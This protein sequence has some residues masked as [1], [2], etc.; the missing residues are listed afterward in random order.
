MIAEDIM[1]REPL[2]VTE[3]VSIGEA[4]RVLSEAGI[5]HLPVVRGGDVVGILS[6]R[7]FT[8]LGLALVNDVERYDQLR[9]RLSR[10]VS[11]L[12]SGSVVSVSREAPVSEIVELM[13]E[14]KLGAVPVVEGNT[15]E[16]AG[17]VSY[18]DVLRAA[19]DLLDGE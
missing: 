7:D 8:G 6:D 5:R 4:L 15:L 12:M 14:E 3:T 13:L 10:P 17:I 16:L 11:T 2:T 9:A 1:T 18:V 19:Q